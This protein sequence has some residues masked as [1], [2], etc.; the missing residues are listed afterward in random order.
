VTLTQIK[1]LLTLVSFNGWTFH[2]AETD[3]GAM[4]LQVRFPYP[5]SKTGLVEE[6]HGRKWLL[7]QHA[8]KSEIVATAFKAV[9]T[10]VEHE[11]RESFTYK[12]SAI[13]GP[14]FDVDFLHSAVR[15]HGDDI[16]DTRAA[17]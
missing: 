1:E 8:T 13:F 10:A 4:F 9:M 15:E 14:H 11:V 7:S 3:K 17:L 12:G 2:V 6:Q 16:E 5:D